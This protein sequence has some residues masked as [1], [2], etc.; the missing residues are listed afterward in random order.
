MYL[1]S[2][3]RLAIAK[4]FLVFFLSLSSVFSFSNE[5][6]HQLCVNAMSEVA[7]YV[8]ANREIA[9]AQF[10]TGAMTTEAYE[11][12]II[13]LDDVDASV[14]MGQCMAGEKT[15][16]YQCLLNQKGNHAACR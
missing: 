13:E 15:V 1:W 8:K 5:P 3:Y 12:L 2:V 9:A 16:L 11:Q 6:D 14:S 7:H 4:S 10:N